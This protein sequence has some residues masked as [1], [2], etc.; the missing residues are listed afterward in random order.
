MNRS[1][2]LLLIVILVASLAFRLYVYNFLLINQQVSLPVSA[3]FMGLA[4]F[5]LIFYI[6]RKL[7]N[8]RI[9]LLA[10]LLYAISPWIAYLEVIS[11]PYIFLLTFFLAL[12]LSTQVLNISRKFFLISVLFIITI[13]L[14]KF[15]QITIFSDV[16]LI[17][18]VNSFR[19]ETNLT[20]F[21]SVGKV[22]ENRYIYLSEHLLF[23]ILKQFTPATYFTNQARLLDF[24]F[25]P[26][27]YL[28]FIIPFL[29]GLMKLI[30]SFTKNDIPKAA[31]VFILM[32]PSILSNTSP[33]LSRLIIVSPII[34][35][36]ISSGLF[37]FILN[38]KKS[39]FRFLLF[40]TLFLVVL[41]LSI[42]ISDIATRE[43]VRLQNL[44]T[45]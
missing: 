4:N 41:Q 27:I 3:I 17:N 13:F 9:G 22:I 1:A 26:P 19:G 6:I 37:T 42:T 40:L 35:L 11:S 44:N 2:Y 21:A 38:Y 10:V 7:A 12:F 36:I 25:A 23:N 31:F 16:G 33:D 18:A 30:K 39:V 5:I 14:Y 29:F 28:G 43:P 32:L 15:N 24:S 8:Y 45:K 34:F 20:I